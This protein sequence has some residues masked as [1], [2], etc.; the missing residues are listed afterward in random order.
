[1]KS[2]RNLDKS[3]SSK[4]DTAE[5]IVR[6]DE[7]V[8]KNI[9]ELMGGNVESEFPILPPHTL[10]VNIEVGNKLN[11]NLRQIRKE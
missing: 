10:T 2:K 7:K 4:E 1:M 5:S 9:V 6:G 8:V 3:D 11:L